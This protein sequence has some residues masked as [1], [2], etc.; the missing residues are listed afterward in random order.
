[1]GDCYTRQSTRCKMEQNPV[2]MKR[3]RGEKE[4][5]NGVYMRRRQKSV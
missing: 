3:R 2:E 1:M 4:G 5:R